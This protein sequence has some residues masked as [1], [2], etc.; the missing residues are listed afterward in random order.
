MSATLLQQRCL[1][2]SEREAIARCPSCGFYFC[3]EC[4]TE[5]D[6]RILCA[7]C[8]KKQNTKTE[9][10]RRNFAPVLRT[11]AALCGLLTAW[12]F[13]Y[14]VGRVLLATPTQFH[15]AT[16]WKSKV[17]DEMQKGETP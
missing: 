9:R 2:H 4:I 5:H 11:M 17:E 3:R 7:S 6:E 16:L 12:F 15:E 1:N 14:V 10:P 8:L 13:F